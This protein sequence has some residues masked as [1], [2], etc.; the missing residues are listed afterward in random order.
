MKN[1][2]AFFA[3]GALLLALAAAPALAQDEYY[4]PGEEVVVR[5]PHFRHHRAIETPDIPGTPIRD[6]AISRPVRFD[7]LD[8]RTRHGVHLLRARISNTARLLCRETD[9]MF[10][11]KTD[12]S[13]PC[14]RTA[15]RDAMAQANEAI[16][17]ANESYE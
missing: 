7:D 8:L 1:R 17:E 14:Y 6:V 15:V 5:A 3:G 16:R 11:V 9:A 4:G 2:S 13:P 12:D 10:P